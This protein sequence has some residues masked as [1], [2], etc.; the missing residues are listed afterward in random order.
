MDINQL[1]Q[2]L[3]GYPELRYSL[4]KLRE[5]KPLEQIYS[6]EVFCSSG[7]GNGLSMNDA[8]IFKNSS[9]ASYL[10]MLSRKYSNLE[11]D[12]FSTVIPSEI[13]FG[14][15]NIS[16]DG[17]LKAILKRYAKIFDDLFQISRGEHGGP[18]DDV[19]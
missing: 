7:E 5:S 15:P 4:R 11:F 9:P 3:S 12:V 13:S 18:V 6:A 1:E 14:T 19:D 17:S 16:G 8:L 10:S 2:F